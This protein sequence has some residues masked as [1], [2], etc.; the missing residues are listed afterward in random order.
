[1]SI[2]PRFEKEKGAKITNSSIVKV[3]K[4]NHILDVKHVAKKCNNF[5]KIKKLSKFEYMDLST[6][7]IIAYNN[8]DS[9]VGN[10]GELYKTFK[11]IR[12]LINTNFVGNSNELFITLTYAENMQSQDKLQQDFKLFWRRLKKAYGNNID[13]LN[14]V[15][16]QERG[17]YHCHVLARFNDIEK[18]YIPND[19]IYKLWNHGF[20][21]TKATQNIDNIGAYLSAYLSD[22]EVTP[23]TKLEKNSAIIEKDIDGMKKKFIKGAR[24]KYYPAGFNI[25]RKS[26][27]INE[28]Q[29]VEM[30]YRDFKK[31]V[32]NKK[33]QHSTTVTI[34]DEH[35]I[36]KVLNKISYEN[37][38]LKR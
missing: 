8:K 23:Q 35:D 37:Y 15:E 21:T 34:S 19:E 30:L 33:P 18:I 4:M 12:D 14:V 32:G 29:E 16:P 24:L 2:I 11:K 22:I 31:I 1:V 5:S 27:G 17:A 38:N 6:G 3:K 20:T 36:D 13:Y 7:E 10:I 9:R 26:K 28:P 25:Y